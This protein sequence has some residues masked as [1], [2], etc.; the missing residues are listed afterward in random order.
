MHI[1]V[2]SCPSPTMQDPPPLALLLSHS[3]QN[4]QF[5][6]PLPS[7]THPVCTKQVTLQNLT[8]ETHLHH[9]N[10][11]LIFSVLNM[12]NTQRGGG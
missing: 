3:H 10:Q 9:P 2:Q 7:L 1:S 11:F 5:L 4:F 8:Q 12:F 6:P